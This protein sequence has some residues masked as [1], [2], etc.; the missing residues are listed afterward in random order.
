M[1]P[2]TMAMLAGGGLNIIG[3][4]FGASAASEQ[5]R[6]AERLMNEAIARIS[7]LQIPDI[8]KKIIYDQY[9]SVGDFTPQMLDKVIEENA[10]LALLKEDPR[11]KA[12]MQSTLAELEQRTKGPSAQYEL[13]LEKARKRTAQDVLAQMASIESEA[14]RTGTYGAGASIAAKLKAA[15]AGAERQ[16]TA[17]L[18]AAAQAEQ[19]Q[20]QNLENFI[21]NLGAENDRS[22]N[23]QSSNVQARNLRDE[24]LMKNAMAR[25]QMNKQAMNQ[26]SLRNLEE[27]QRAFNANIGTNIAEQRRLGYEAPMKM[28]EMQ[29]GRINALN[30]AT[31]GLA[32]TYLQRGQAAQQAWGNIAGGMSSLASAYAMGNMRGGG[33]GGGESGGYS[34]GGFNP[35]TPYTPTG[36]NYQPSTPLM[37][38]VNVKEN[39]EHVGNDNTTGLPIYDF[40]YKGHEGR[41]RGVIAQD[42]EKIMPQA[43]TTHKGIKYVDYNKLGLKMFKLD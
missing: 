25:E 15:Q 22:M 33:Y 2:V 30:Q 5:A 20:G 42:V 6:K 18:E 26:A 27:R 40:N 23:V 43:V 10:P 11:Y 16:S 17:G 7:A 28:Y 29:L 36:F 1:D 9:M 4:L 8:T 32:N 34:G 14:K 12:K 41:Y 35:N 24:L 3:N 39:I 21:K 13:N 31:G 37:S 19:L 38:D